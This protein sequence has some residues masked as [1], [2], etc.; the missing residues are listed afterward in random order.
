MVQ[1]LNTPSPTL[2]YVFIFQAAY[3]RLYFIVIFIYT[4]RK[5]SQ[6]LVVWNKVGDGYVEKELSAVR[7][8]FFTARLP[9][10]V[11]YT[12]IVIIVF[13]GYH[14]VDGVTCRHHTCP[15]ASHFT[16]WNMIGDE[17]ATRLHDSRPCYKRQC[18][19]LFWRRTILLNSS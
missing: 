15:P 5:P 12:G 19:T 18:V 4:L 13:F 9:R 2:T 11:K 7:V 3:C 17:I 6:S 16:C 10:L 8:H 14:M 1:P